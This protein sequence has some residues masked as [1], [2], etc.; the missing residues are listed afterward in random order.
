MTTRRLTFPKPDRLAPHERVDYR[1]FKFAKDPRTPDPNFRGY[2]RGLGCQVKKHSPKTHPRC[3][4]IAGTNYT[5]RPVIDFCHTPTGGTGKAMGRKAS[6]LRNG[7]GM[8]HALGVEQ[9]TI[10]WP[11]FERKYEINAREIAQDIADEYVR[12]FKK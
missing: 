9:E 1:G 12:R 8:C 10:G 3:A 7:I 4:N 5:P 2:V 6:D 11:A